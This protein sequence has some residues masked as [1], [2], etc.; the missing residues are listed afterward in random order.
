MCLCL[1]RRWIARVPRERTAKGVRPRCVPPCVRMAL[2]SCVSGR[3][4]GAARRTRWV[5]CAGGVP[6]A[7]VY[8][9]EEQ[10]GERRLLGRELDAPD[11]EAQRVRHD[12]PR[13][14]AVAAL[15]RARVRDVDEPR[16][17]ARRLVVV[18]Q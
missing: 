18:R 8:V 3:A 11:V 9:A 10:R 7:G 12:A 17:G 13:G 1:G 6:L 15:L 16:H 5:L 4:K 14:L 2:H